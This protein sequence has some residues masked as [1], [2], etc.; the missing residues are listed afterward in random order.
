MAQDHDCINQ[1]DI[2]ELKHKVFGNGRPGIAYT[3]ERL[4]QRMQHLEGTMKTIIGLQVT[5]IC[6]IL[7]AVLA[8]LIK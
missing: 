2:D 3:V 8:V 7:A 4:D 1:K 6:V 5:Q